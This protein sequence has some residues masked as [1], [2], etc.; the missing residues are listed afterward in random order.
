V[1]Q[2]NQEL[3]YHVQDLIPP[4]DFRTLLNQYPDKAADITIDLNIPHPGESDS[5]YS[6]RLT[7]KAIYNFVATRIGAGSS[8]NKIYASIAENNSQVGK[9]ISPICGLKI[10]TS[11]DNNLDFFKE[12]DETNL[13]FTDLHIDE[14]PY[15]T[16]ADFEGKQFK[17]LD[18]QSSV[19]N[20]VRFKINSYRNYV[21]LPKL[22]NGQQSIL[23]KLNHVQDVNFQDW[24]EL[25]SIIELPSQAKFLLIFPKAS[26]PIPYR[27][28]GIAKATIS[29]KINLSMEIT[30]NE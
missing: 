18:Y 1:I 14:V 2:I 25:K 23:T 8:I 22:I 12:I 24:T 30:R 4:Q 16:F 20:I 21:Y 27:R 5:E 17:D 28:V 19:T 13:N 9:S 15:S 7:P 29:V 3:V 26:L 6:Y 11:N 10:Y